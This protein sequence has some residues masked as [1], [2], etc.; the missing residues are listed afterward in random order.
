[1]DGKGGKTRRGRGGSDK[2][3]GALAAA[4]KAD[5]GQISS[6]VDGG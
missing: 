2:S 6:D 5:E 1:M 3:A 4:I